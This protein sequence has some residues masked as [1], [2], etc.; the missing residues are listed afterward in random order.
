M[1]SDMVMVT[2]K[3]PQGFWFALPIHCSA[4]SFSWP[5][6]F[7]PMVAPML[8]T[9]HRAV[10]PLRQQLPKGPSMTSPSASAWC[11][12]S[13][14][15]THARLQAERGFFLTWLLL[16]DF[17]L[18]GSSHRYIWTDSYNPS[19]IPQITEWLCF[20]EWILTDTVTHITY[21]Y[22]YTHIVYFIVICCI[23]YM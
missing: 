5:L 18:P 2:V 8:T 11:G 16:P 10:D 17:H 7:M 15:S 12:G 19:F 1:Q 4:F 22:I 23:P 6:A 3:V 20:S 9:R 13:G 14:L 21:K